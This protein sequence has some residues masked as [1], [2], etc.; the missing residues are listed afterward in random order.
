MYSDIACRPSR[1]VAPGPAGCRITLA[2]LP[3]SQLRGGLLPW[4]GCCS[5]GVPCQHAARPRVRTRY[6]DFEVGVRDEGDEERHELLQSRQ[7]L[8]PVAHIAQGLLQAVDGRGAGLRTAWRERAT[9]HHEHVAEYLPPLSWA[10]FGPLLAAD[11]PGVHLATQHP[12]TRLPVTDIL[13]ILH[14]GRRHKAELHPGRPV[15]RA[16]ALPRHALGRPW[17]P[18]LN[19]AALAH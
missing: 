1:P 14:H 18:L 19:A 8:R 10:R 9:G 17:V 11:R 5:P 7:E 4:R 13:Q 3:W 15:R 2:A 12:L 6:G 16:A